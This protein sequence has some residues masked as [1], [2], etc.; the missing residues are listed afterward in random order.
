M[1]FVQQSLSLVSESDK[2]F[3]VKNAPNDLSGV[4]VCA[5]QILNSTERGWILKGTSGKMKSRSDWGRADSWRAVSLTGA[6]APITRCYWLNRGH[7][8]EMESNTVT[9]L[10][11]Q[12]HLII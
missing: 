7:I 1:C 2:Y 11:V 4:C 5:S 9:F 12:I 8:K 10:S 3:S 6:A